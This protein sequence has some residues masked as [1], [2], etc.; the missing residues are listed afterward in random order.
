M[1][2][3]SNWLSYLKFRASYGK[4]GNDGIVATPR[5]VFLPIIDRLNNP[6]YANPQPG[7]ATDYY[8]YIVS[9]YPNKDIEWE[10]AEQINFGMEAK[11]FSGI[12]EFTL[13]AFQEIRHNVIGN[14][15]TLPSSAGV[16]V[17]P[18]AN[19][20]K[21]RMRGIDFSGKVQHAFSQDCWM[22]LNG[23]LTYSKSI[24]KEIRT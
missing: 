9:A 6:K 23:T 18:L 13:D 20:G 5:F 8:R 3:V 10:I 1:Q 2:S 16:E 14:K 4:V 22:I 12:L 21:S 15:N 11:M 24:Y 7:G 19:I 17:A